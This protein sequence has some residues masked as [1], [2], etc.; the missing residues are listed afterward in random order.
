LSAQLAD[1]LVVLAHVIEREGEPRLHKETVSVH[2]HVVEMVGLR[3]V[4]GRA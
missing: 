3:F 2:E 4:D 1:L